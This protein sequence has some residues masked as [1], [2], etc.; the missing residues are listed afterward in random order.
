MANHTNQTEGGLL[1]FS[2]A[3]SLQGALFWVTEQIRDG[4]A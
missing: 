1:S 4:F 3:Q 2:P